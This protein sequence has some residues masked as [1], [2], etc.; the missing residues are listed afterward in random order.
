MEYKVSVHNFGNFKLDGGS[1]FGPV[2]KVLWEKH[3]KPD[4]RNRIPMATNSLL[5]ENNKQR[6]L[7]DLGLGMKWTDKEKDIYAIEDRNEISSP[8]TITDIIFTHL[9]FDHCGGVSYFDKDNNL[10]LNYPNANIYVQ[11]ENFELGLKPNLREKPSYR[12]ENIEIL[13]E[14]NLNLLEGDTE[15]FPGINTHVINGHTKGQIWLTVNTG[16]KTIAYPGDLM[17]TSYHQKPS[18]HM[19]MDMNVEVLLS[20]KQNFNNLAEKNNWEIVFQ[21]GV[22]VPIIIRQ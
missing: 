18:W 20:E 8:E 10:K 15:V 11:K 6:I 12:Q 1:M 9:H 13:K 21:H 7:V 3:I 2:P 19:G 17:P 5:I 16:S 14:A 22:G 4:E